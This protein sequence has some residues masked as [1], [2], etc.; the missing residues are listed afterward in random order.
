LGTSDDEAA[1]AGAAGAAGLA[2]DGAALAETAAEAAEADFDSCSSAETAAIAGV[3]E[4]DKLTTIRAPIKVRII[5]GLT[6]T[7]SSGKQK[8]VAPSLR[9]TE[10]QYLALANLSSSLA[11]DFIE[12]KQ[13]T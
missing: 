5:F 1:A 3:A 8:M 12:Q 7:K 2:P 13:Q 9:A 4:A 10:M 6:S 11:P